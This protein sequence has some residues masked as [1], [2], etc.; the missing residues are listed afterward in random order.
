METLKK[1]LLA[2]LLVSILGGLLAARA[3]AGWFDP[4]KFL[5]P[6][7]TQV[8]K[9]GGGWYTYSLVLNNVK[10]CFLTKDPGW[11]ESMH[12]T[13]SCGVPS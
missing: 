11:K 6:N 4:H 12:S 13:I 7:A 2:T 8:V 3:H 1:I 5:P 10:Q 9:L